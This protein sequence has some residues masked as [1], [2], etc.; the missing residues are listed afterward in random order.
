MHQLG[1]LTNLIASLRE[2]EK[3]LIFNTG[4]GVCMPL[5]CV[6]KFGWALDRQFEPGFCQ[7]PL[8]S[9]SGRSSVFMGLLYATAITASGGYIEISHL[10]ADLGMK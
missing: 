3:K 8:C 9:H 10:V 1:Q 5:T 6:E 7:I 4:I 2:S